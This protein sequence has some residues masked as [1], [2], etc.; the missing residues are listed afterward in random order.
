MPFLFC[1]YSQ[2]WVIEAEN[3]ICQDY[4]SCHS[5]LLQFLKQ[6]NAREEMHDLSSSSSFFFFLNESSSF[7]PIL[8]HLWGDDKE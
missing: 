2:L 8:A 5:P 4:S 1:Y 3:F 7:Q 6:K